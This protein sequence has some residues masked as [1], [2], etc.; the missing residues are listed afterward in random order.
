MQLLFVSSYS[1]HTVCVLPQA[2]GQY[3]TG[4]FGACYLAHDTHPSPIETELET[5]HNGP[6]LTCL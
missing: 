3:I 2:R 4:L 6:S 1:I 5:A